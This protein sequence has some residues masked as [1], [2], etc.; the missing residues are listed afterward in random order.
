MDT[1]K[2]P[3]PN[4]FAKYLQEIGYKKHQVFY[5]TAPAGRMQMLRSYWDGGSRD[6][7]AAWNAEGKRI[8]LPVG[9]SYFEKMPDGYTPAPGDVLIR[10]GVF[11]GKPATAD[12]TV[13]E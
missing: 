9:G 1:I 12:I 7:Y 10:Y 4:P 13:Y 8:P 11:C 5:S 2:K 6:Y 3:F